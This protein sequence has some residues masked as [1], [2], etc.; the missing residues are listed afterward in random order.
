MIGVG[1]LKPFPEVRPPAPE[2]VDEMVIAPIKTRVVADSLKSK[3]I[4]NV[5]RAVGRR[6][7]T[8]VLAWALDDWAAKTTPG[9]A[10]SGSSE[11]PAAQRMIA[12]VIS[13]WTGTTPPPTPDMPDAGV[14]D[15]GA[16]EPAEEI[17]NQGG[18]GADASVAPLSAGPTRPTASTDSCG[19]STPGS[20]RDSGAPAVASVV[21]LLGAIAMR[22]RARR[23]LSQSSQRCERRERRERR[24]TN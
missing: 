17:E 8:D 3:L 20:H 13:R 24:N 11:S 22:L 5:W 4:R 23:R 15:A 9:F 6:N 21:A 1:Q 10:I 18:P 14:F 16:E 19:C 12:N 2:A 7:R